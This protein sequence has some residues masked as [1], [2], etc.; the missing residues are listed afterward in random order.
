MTTRARKSAPAWAG[1]I[2]QEMAH[3]DPLAHWSNAHIS[4]WQIRI[5]L[6]E[7]KL[8][9]ATQWLAER[10]LSLDGEIPFIHEADYVAMARVL[11]AQGRLAK[12]TELLIRLQGVAEGGGRYLRVIELL[13]LQALTAHANA[14]LPRALNLLEQALHLG[15]PRG[16]IRT[17]VDEGPALAQLLYEA[18]K[19]ELSPEYVQRIIAAFPTVMPEPIAERSSQENEWIEPLTDRELEILQL[20]AEGLSNQ[21][22]S[23][24]LYL[25]ANT[26]KTHLRNL[27]GKL[28]VNSRTQAVAK[29]RGLG[30]VLDR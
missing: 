30:I 24:Q 16:I 29:A 6:A 11:L 7:G 13:L 28:G 9:V 2:L 22:V 19:H 18:I 8:D 21:E 4:A 12:A 1:A 26:V 5:W 25:S 3:T 10:D 14:D 20:V 15:E 23:K 17:F 27:Y